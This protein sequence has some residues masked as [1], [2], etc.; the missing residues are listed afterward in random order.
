MIN[1]TSLNDNELMSLNAMVNT[2]K[3]KCPFWIDNSIGVAAPFDGYGIE[4]IKLLPAADTFLGV[5]GD[6]DFH[7]GAAVISSNPQGVQM[8]DLI[9]KHPT[10]HNIMLVRN[11]QDVG[12]PNYDLHLNIMTLAPFYSKYNEII[13]VDEPRVLFSQI[14]FDATLN[15]PKVSLACSDVKALEANLKILFEEEQDGDIGQIVK[16]TILAKHTCK[17]RAIQ[18]ANA[19]K[20]SNLA[21]VLE[22]I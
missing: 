1:V 5:E 11:Q 22:T 10:Y 19:L 20:A 3:I 21:K 9:Q 14:F 8:N 6:F 15:S 16:D 18:F 2:H 7:I 4:T 13:L 12:N 17:Q